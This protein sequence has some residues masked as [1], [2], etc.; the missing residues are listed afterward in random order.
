M[1]A[2][3]VRPSEPQGQAGGCDPLRPEPLGGLSLSF[4]DGRIEID[5]NTL[6][7]AIRPLASNWKNAL[8]AGS[9]G[10]GEHRAVI[11]ALV[12]ICKLVGVEP[13]AYLA[14]VITSIVEGHPQRRLDDL[15]PWTYPATPVLR[16]VA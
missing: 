12:M 1:A 11:A 7:R 13:Q 2:G 3:K 6:E 8:F 5:S 4:D 14:D 9:N 15:L 10:G 16:A